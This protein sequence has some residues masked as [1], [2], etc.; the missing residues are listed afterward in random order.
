MTRQYYPRLRSGPGP[1]QQSVQSVDIVVS[2]CG[3]MMSDQF[4]PARK[5]LLGARVLHHRLGLQLG[6]RDEDVVQFLVEL[7]D[8]LP[9]RAQQLLSGRLVVKPLDP[10][11]H[12]PRYHA[13][14]TCGR[15]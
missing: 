2:S 5:A 1:G 3:V 13:F 8:V 14:K 4:A 7:D 15:R 9:L 11:Q 12:L 10:R 6:V